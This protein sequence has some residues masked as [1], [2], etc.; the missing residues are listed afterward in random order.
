MQKMGV[1]EIRQKVC[2]ELLLLGGRDQFWAI[3]NK[4][5]YLRFP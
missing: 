5:I 1:R 3:L 2:T 4:T